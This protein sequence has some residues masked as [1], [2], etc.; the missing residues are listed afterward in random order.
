MTPSA[1]VTYH[2]AAVYCVASCVHWVVVLGAE[3]ADAG[4]LRLRTAKLL[5]EVTRCSCAEA[6]VASVRRGEV[7]CRLKPSLSTPHRRRSPK[8]LET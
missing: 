1:V 4:G 7:T 3:I 8:R 2:P 6:L 5:L